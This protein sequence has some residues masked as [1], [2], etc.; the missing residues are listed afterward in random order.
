MQKGGKNAFEVLNVGMKTEICAATLAAHLG[1]QPSAV[2]LVNLKEL[3][4]EDLMCANV[5]QYKEELAKAAAAKQKL[6]ATYDSN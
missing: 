2:A 6:G 1:L 5:A 3:Q 4:N